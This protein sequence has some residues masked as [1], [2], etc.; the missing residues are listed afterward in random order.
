MVGECALWTRGHHRR[1]ASPTRLR[2]PRSLGLL[3]GVSALAAAIGVVGAV[4]LLAPPPPS[5]EV[6]AALAPAQHLAN[7][8]LLVQGFGAS[9]FAEVDPSA[10][11]RSAPADHIQFRMYMVFAYGGDV[12]AGVD[13]VV[14]HPEGDGWCLEYVELNADPLL[15]WRDGDLFLAGCAVDAAA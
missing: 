3:L 12:P 9:G 1:V 14:Y 6:S 7:T 15:H 2:V 8:A 13:N 5:A 10:T 4:L 11:G